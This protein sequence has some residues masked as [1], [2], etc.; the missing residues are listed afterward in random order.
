MNATVTFSKYLASIDMTIEGETLT[1]PSMRSMVSWVKGVQSTPEIT[2]TAMAMGAAAMPVY[3]I[4]DN[5]EVIVD[6]K[7]AEA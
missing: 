3:K 4:T 5:G 2:I 7:K 1:F 6:L